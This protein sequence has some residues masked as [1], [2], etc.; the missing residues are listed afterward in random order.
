MQRS[1]LKK[2]ILSANESIKIYEADSENSALDVIKNNDINMFLI[3]I[4]LKESS[5][6]DLAVKIRN[7]PKYEFRQIIFLTTHMEYIVQAFK[8]THCY[9]YILKPYDKEKVQAMI[10]KL[11]DNDINNLTNKEE[12]TKEEK[13]EVI[14][15]IK[16]GI[17]VG[18]KVDD[19]VFIEV[20][21]KNCEVNTINGMYIASNMSLKKML[22]L[23][24][25]DYIIQS[26]RAFVV[27]KNYILEIEKIDVKLSTI[28]FKDYTKTALLGYKFKDS[29]MSEFKKGKVVLC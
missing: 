2:I 19:I 12:E 14:I 29:V 25:C 9:D 20:I 15:N 6:L 3:D 24:D 11:V 13:K 5:G 17:Y 28:H 16:N 26:H 21:G 7:I 23:I 8:E 4:S 18:V 10:N 27:N 1:I 22:K